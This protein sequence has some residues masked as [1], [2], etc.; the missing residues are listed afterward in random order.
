MKLEK[1]DYGYLTRSKK[2]KALVSMLLVIV[3][4]LVIGFGY[5]RY[6]TMKTIFTVTGILF[7]LPIAKILSGLLVTLPVRS[8]PKEKYE[9]LKNQLSEVPKEQILWDMA[10]SSQEKVRYFPCIV[11]SDKAVLVYYEKHS[12]QT[13]ND[14]AKAYFRSLLQNNCHRQ[15]FSFFTEEKAF[16]NQVSAHLWSCENNEEANRLRETICVYGM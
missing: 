12:K 13:E 5:W 4:L 16:L 6:H 7:A 3:M 14:E 8:L 2:R 9:R 15:E 11:F 10:L 1:G